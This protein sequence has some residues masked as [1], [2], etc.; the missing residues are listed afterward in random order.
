MVPRVVNAAPQ[1]LTH[2]SALAQ[3]QRDRERATGLGCETQTSGMILGAELARGLGVQVYRPEHLAA[4]GDGQ[5]QRPLQPLLARKRQIRRP[6]GLAGRVD[7][8]HDFVLVES[9]QARPG[10]GAVLRLVQAQRERVTAAHR[11]RPASGAAYRDPARPRRTEFRGRLHRQPVEE[12]I[13]GRGGQ[14]QLLQLIKM[15]TA[16]LVLIGF[17]HR[18][19]HLAIPEAP[20]TPAWALTEDAIPGDGARKGPTAIT[21]HPN[22]RASVTDGGT[23]RPGGRRHRRPV[24]AWPRCRL[25]GPGP[26][27]PARRRQARHDRGPLP[28]VDHLR[29][30]LAAARAA[31]TALTNPGW[32]QARREL[33]AFSGIGTGHRGRRSGTRCPPTM[34]RPPA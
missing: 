17:R 12:L 6:P 33:T 15:R 7:H 20:R 13:E 18:G 4:R 27:L 29:D 3:A 30:H 24:R 9:L 32:P 28:L 21:R 34:P 1:L 19:G 16:H 26:R 2:I 14:Q 5:R 10:L 31:G 22:R 23:G 25:P 11:H 8:G